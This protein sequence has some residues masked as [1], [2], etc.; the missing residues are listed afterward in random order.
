MP[1]RYM[2]IVLMPL[3]GLLTLAAVLLF[4][5]LGASPIERAEIYFLDGARNM[6]ER[7]D[8][9]VP[10]YRGQPFFDKPALTYWLMAASFQAL[11]FTL[12]AARIVGLSW[13]A[14]I[15]LRLGVEPLAHFFL[16]ENLERFAA[17]TYDVGRRAWWYY[18]RAYLA[19]GLPRS[20]FLAVASWHVLRGDP[21]DRHS[22]LLLGWK[23]TDTS[24]QLPHE[25]WA[26]ITPICTRKCSSQTIANRTLRRG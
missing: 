13:F 26:S 25:I 10:Y 15:Y 3:L 6:L 19:F 1:Q 14:I 21:E 5:G 20:P 17:A 16:R 8:Y 22:R 2:T 23:W 11:G 7:Q 9:L 24:G 12:S 18:L 4:P